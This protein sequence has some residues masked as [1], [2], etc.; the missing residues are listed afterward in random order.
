MRRS[1]KTF[2]AWER[3]R[4]RRKPGTAIAASH[5]HDFHER[6]TAA[7]FGGEFVKHFREVL[8]GMSII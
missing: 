2:E 7:V 4:E 5:D 8:S 1:F 3:L 6:K